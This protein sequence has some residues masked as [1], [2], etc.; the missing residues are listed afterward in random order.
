VALLAVNLTRVQSVLQERQPLHVCDVMSL[1]AR[2]Q[3]IHAESADVKRMSVC[4]ALDPL[5]ERQQSKQQFVD[6]ARKVNILQPVK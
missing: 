3:V 6:L 4:V 5:H 1:N 2:Y